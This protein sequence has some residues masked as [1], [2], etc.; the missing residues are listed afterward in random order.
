MDDAIETFER[1]ST[2]APDDADIL[3]NLGSAYAQTGNYDQGIELY[4]RALQINPRLALAYFGLG[5]LYLQKGE[6]AAAREALN[7]FLTLSDDPDLRT[8]AQ[9]MLAEL[10]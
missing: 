4:N 1:A 8:R 5:T 9:E 6:T 3:Y 2:I 7:Q 10:Q